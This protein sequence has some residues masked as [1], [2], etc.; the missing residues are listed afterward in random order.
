V[1]PSG[2]DLARGA[3]VAAVAILVA[4]CGGDAGDDVVEPA[5]VLSSPAVTA[6]PSPPGPTA[7][8][9]TKKDDATADHLVATAGPDGPD[10]DFVLRGAPAVADEAAELEVEDQRGDGRSVRVAG[11]RLSS[12]TG[13]VGIYDAGLDLL[14]WA[15]VGS[16]AGPV[17]VALDRRL[18]SSQELVAVLYRDAGDG[19]LDASDPVVTEEGEQVSEDFDYLLG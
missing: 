12:R 4:G 17:S 18:G 9:A 8:T 2:S 11:V 16:G 14:G 10:D 6:D 15:V 3:V 1:R 13:I 19:R 5:V 7:G